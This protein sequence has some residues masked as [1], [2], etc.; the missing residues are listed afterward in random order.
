MAVKLEHHDELAETHEMNVVPFIDIMLV[1]LIIFMV[2]AP[3]A[4]VDVD[5]NLPSSTAEPAP[6]P[7]QP[8]FLTIKADHSIVLGTDPV[9]FSALGAALDR[10]AKGDKQARIFVRADKSVDYGILMQALNKLRSAGYLRIA[11]VG[12]DQARR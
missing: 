2:A 10:A 12:L 5:V 11:L 4:T 6:R 7:D 3:L 1:L 9:R 8:I